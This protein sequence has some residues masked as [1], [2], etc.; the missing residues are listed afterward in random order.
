MITLVQTPLIGPTNP[1]P[2]LLTQRVPDM[3]PAVIFRETEAF[4]RITPSPGV[5]YCTIL[6]EHGKLGRN[7]DCIMDTCM[8]AIYAHHASND[9]IQ[10]V[11]D[12]IHAQFQSGTIVEMKWIAEVKRL[13]ALV[14][15]GVP[16][17]GPTSAERRALKTILADALRRLPVHAGGQWQG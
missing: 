4:I 5:R 16:I 12:Y 13:R 11:F 15:H 6:L 8:K 10:A 2:P 3:D 9:Y 17:L 1:F 7:I 14:R